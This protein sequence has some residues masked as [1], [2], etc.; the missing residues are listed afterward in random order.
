MIQLLRAL[1]YKKKE[2]RS[3]LKPLKERATFFLSKLRQSAG[4]TQ[5]RCVVTV[6]GGS[7]AT[8]SEPK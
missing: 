2:F 4:Q 8:T 7:E 3:S 1:A 5:E 6:G